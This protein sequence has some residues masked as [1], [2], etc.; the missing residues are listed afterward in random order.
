MKTI[1]NANVQLLSTSESRT[2]Q[3]GVLSTKPGYYVD[4]ILIPPSIDPNDHL[5]VANY[6]AWLGSGPSGQG[7][8]P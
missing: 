5:V 2:I 4:G 8:N 7:I 1:K 6:L 3:G